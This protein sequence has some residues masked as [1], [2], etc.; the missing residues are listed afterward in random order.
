MSDK[1]K[2]TYY[3]YNR[4]KS[5]LKKNEEKQILNNGKKICQSP[6]LLEVNILLDIYST[7]RVSE[8]SYYGWKLFFYDEEYKN[9]S[10]TVKKV[11]ALQE[12]VNRHRP[13]AEL[14]TLNNLEAGVAFPIDMYQ[15]C[16][17]DIF[18]NHWENFE[19][20][21]HIKPTHSLNCIKL[22][23]HQIILETLPADNI[24][25][26]LNA[27][28]AFPM[29]RI[30]LLNYQPLT[31][32]RDIKI[33]YYG[34]LT[35]TRGCVIRV[36]HVKH[37]VQWIMF[38]CS[39]CHTKKMFKQPQ[40]IYTVP[41]KCNVC[42]V[43]KFHPMLD[44]PNLKSIMFQI[45]KL[46]ELL[47][48]EQE[49]KGRM[50]RILEVLL[51]DNL[52]NTCMPGDDII[53]T[54]IIKMQ[55]VDDGI[56]KTKTVKAVSLY[57]EAV[58]IINDKN[59]S[60]NKSIVDS[61][62]CMKDYLAIKE[63]YH[64]PHTFSLL[65]H[66]LCPAIYGHEIVKAGLLLS[67]FG[68]NPK[69]TDLRD[70]IHVLLVGDPGLGKSQMLQACTRV[71]VK[72][73]YV[74]GNTS[75]SSGLTVTFTKGNG[76]NDYALE[77]GALVLADKG[78]CCIDEFDKML[79]QHQSLLES[80]E[81]QTVS[82]AKSGVVCSL[83][84]RASILAAANPIGGRYDKSKTI[85]QNLNVSQPL[86]SRFDLVFL[87]LDIPN[88]HL[89]ALLCKHVIE[90]HKS[91]NWVDNGKM[92]TMQHASSKLYK[93]ACSLRE[94]LI[95][96]KQN[97]NCIPQPVLQKYIS[98]ARQYVK[99]CL[100]EEAAKVLQKYYLQL[101]NKN[102]AF[103]GLPV[104]SRQLEAMIRLTE[105]RAKLELRTEATEMDALDVIEILE[106]TMR[107]MLDSSLTPD[108]S[109]SKNDKLTNKKLKAFINCMKD[110]KKVYEKH[111]FS[112]I[113]H[114]IISYNSFGQK[115]I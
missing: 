41:K 48:D 25:T 28:N 51:L 78:C 35:L 81:Q 43:S 98:Y 57:M 22:A 27:I 32:L 75:T 17:D 83:P 46:Q 72:G 105:A 59:R 115:W 79:S 26:Y 103:G 54:G 6:D 63:I 52:V 40:G 60:Q 61:E 70:D 87:L 1:R 38:V 74:C 10:P 89:D 16:K 11:K 62:M 77:P 107:D 102:E 106:F 29:V 86:L 45:V 8:N 65:V 44:S 66:S 7:E 104:F 24:K 2:N 82:V 100:S 99:P 58:T 113:K 108:S 50:P 94:R 5:K 68:G 85:I 49:D 92:H 19:N 71:A 93:N 97:L 31:N 55:G 47:N 64:Q 110:A 69:H 109:L 114:Y 12:F 76:R 34:K 67:L 101:R 91:A 18:L 20:D 3:K 36:G 56:M 9:G 95:F 13:F 111:T 14:L 73:V 96:S 53:I 23:I 4:H 112:T 90:V 15:L 21:I 42:G 33:N 37:L 39:N 84:A 88:E 80:M 30:K